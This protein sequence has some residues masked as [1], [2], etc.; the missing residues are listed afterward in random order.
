M[1]LISAWIKGQSTEVL[2][3][4]V[5]LTLVI[6]GNSIALTLRM[7]KMRNQWQTLLRGVQGENLEKMLYDHMRERATMETDLAGL[8]ERQTVLEDKI[9]SA[10][11]YLGLVRYD[12]FHDIG[13]EQ[14]FSLAVYDDEGNGAILSTL[15]GRSEVRV[16]CKEM[17]NGQANTSLTEEEQKAVRAGVKR[18]VAGGAKK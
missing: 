7:R 8:K 1:E 5:L 17:E 15:V 11:R 2:M 16:Y 18:K 10:K 13:G 3:A 14:S 9:L 6:G 4:L 12:A